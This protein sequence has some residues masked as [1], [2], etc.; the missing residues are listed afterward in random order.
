MSARRSGKPERREAGGGR[1]EAEGMRGF[2]SDFRAPT[3]AHAHASVGMAPSS[4]LDEL[5]F[6]ISTSRLR[7]PASRLLLAMLAFALCCTALPLL[8]AEGEPTAE[9]TD[10][11]IE[12]ARDALTPARD[13]PW[14]DAAKDEL[15]PITLREPFQ[16]FR[17][18]RLPLNWLFYTVIGLLLAGIVYWLLRIY[19]ETRGSKVRTDPRQSERVMDAEQV[20]ALP[21]MADRSRDDLLGE[22]RRHYQLGNYSEAIIYLFSYELVELDKSALIQLAKGKT[23]R[24][25][26]REAGPSRPLGGLLEMTIVT[27]EDVFFGRRPLDRG[28]FD[29][30]WQRLDEFQRLVAGAA[31]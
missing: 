1:P 18:P 17:F 10:W 2:T 6:F 30:C 13:F 5:L 22:A 31:T 23:N 29:A 28:G 3:S 8:A 4:R 16:P 19:W 11:P 27:F 15:R 26:L 20:E 14:Y 21:F 7:P 24:Q 12:A 25:Y 9:S